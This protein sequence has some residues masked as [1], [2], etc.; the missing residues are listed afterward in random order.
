MGNPRKSGL[1][2]LQREAKLSWMW[3]STAL[4][5]GT[6]LSMKPSL[7]D[8][9]R[10]GRASA[11][12]YSPGKDQGI[13]GYVCCVCPGIS[14]MNGATREAPW[15][16]VF[17][18]ETDAQ[19]ESV[20]QLSWCQETARLLVPLPLPWVYWAVA[21][22]PVF[23]KGYG[24]ALQNILLL[25]HH[26]E[27]TD[28]CVVNEMTCQEGCR[29]LLTLALSPSLPKCFYLWGNCRAPASSCT[30]DGDWRNDIK[31]SQLITQCPVTSALCRDWYPTSGVECGSG[32]MLHSYVKCHFW[33]SNERSCCIRSQQWAGWQNGNAMVEFAFA[34]DPCMTCESSSSP[35]LCFALPR[36]QSS[37]SLAWLAVFLLSWL[38]GR[39]EAS[40]LEIDWVF[41]LS[42][43]STPVPSCQGSHLR[44]CSEVLKKPSKGGAALELRSWPSF[45]AWKAAFGTVSMRFLLKS[46][47]CAFLKK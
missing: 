40:F 37:V 25:K 9:K 16:L 2:C 41:Q 12:M 31:R 22:V 42:S 3:N 33:T 14:W 6:A 8:C 46:S 45:L 32:V 11:L 39:T 23:P 34:A 44:C 21:L 15:A 10:W 24:P 5:Q 28:I 27:C 17:K 19:E 29:G 26:R 43:A 1:L 7:P 20:W 47:L 13:A 4:L 38:G 18:Y 30:Q 35:D 36:I